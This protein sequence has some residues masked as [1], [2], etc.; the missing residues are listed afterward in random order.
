MQVSTNY[1]VRSTAYQTPSQ[2]YVSGKLKTL[3]VF[4]VSAS[5]DAEFFLTLSTLFCA[6]EP[7]SANL[8]KTTRLG[9]PCVSE[10][11]LMFDPIER[12]A[13][14][15]FSTRIMDTPNAVWCGIFP[16]GGLRKTLSGTAIQHA[17]YCTYK[18][19]ARSLGC[20]DVI[21]SRL[22]RRFVGAC[23][24]LSDTGQFAA[25]SLCCSRRV[26]GRDNSDHN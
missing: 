2:Q 5:E 14:G 19:P 15:R 21:S 24:H 6:N 16:V 13:E 23:T 7:S 1:S 10:A 4:A 26:S 9:L 12:T 18:H 17:Q 3:H 25:M 20:Q 8:A 11:S 22:P